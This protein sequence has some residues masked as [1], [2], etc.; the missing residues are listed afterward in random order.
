MIT[1]AEQTERETRTATTA[2]LKKGDT[3]VPPR[4]VTDRRPLKTDYRNKDEQEDAEKNVT[5]VKTYMCGDERGWVGQLVMPPHP[6]GEE[7]DGGQAHDGNQGVEQS[8]EELGLLGIWVG[9]G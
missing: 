5:L 8:A 7:D 6:E 2:A 1:A 4:R 3:A 9:G